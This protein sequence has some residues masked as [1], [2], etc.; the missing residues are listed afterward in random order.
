MKVGLKVTRMTQFPLYDLLEKQEYEERIIT[1]II[2]PV[3]NSTTWNY[4]VIQLRILLH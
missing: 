3:Y 1:A 4:I 2:A